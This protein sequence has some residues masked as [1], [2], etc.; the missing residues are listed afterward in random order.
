MESGA[1]QILRQASPS[2]GKEAYP[3]HSSKNILKGKIDCMNHLYDDNLKD[4]RLDNRVFKT[5][6]SSMSPNIIET[7][8]SYENKLKEAEEKLKKLSMAQ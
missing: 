1:N 4:S 5:D 6:D 2:S 8:K 3:H 7:M